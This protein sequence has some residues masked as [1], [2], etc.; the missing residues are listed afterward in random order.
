MQVRVGKVRAPDASSEQ[1]V[2]AKQDPQIGGMES[3]VVWRVSGRKDCAQGN[4]RDACLLIIVAEAMIRAGQGWKQLFQESIIR[5]I[6]CSRGE[7][8]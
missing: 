3:D 4:T 2:A 5:Q 6:G 8:Q 1:A 7:S